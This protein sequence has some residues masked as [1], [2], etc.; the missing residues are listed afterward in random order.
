MIGRFLTDLIRYGVHGATKSESRKRGEDDLELSLQ[1]TS[2][3]DLDDI[4]VLVKA[5]RGWFLANRNDVYLGACL[6]RYGECGEIET[7]FLESLVSAGDTVIE[8][9]SNIGVH[10]VPLAHA[11]GVDGTLIALEPQPAIYRVLCANLALNGL[12]RVH[13]YM[14]GA[15]ATDHDMSVQDGADA[16]GLEHN[17]GGISLNSTGDGLQVKVVRIDELA[18]GLGRIDLIKIDVEGMELEVIKGATETIRKHRPLL[19]VENDRLDKSSTMIQAIM[20]LDYRLY[21][22]LPSLFNP[23]N[24]F[25]VAEDIYHVDSCNMLCVP[26]GRNHPSTEALREVVDADF[27]PWHR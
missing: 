23:D 5:R 27:H 6:L 25:R 4:N 13:P 22:H 26:K 18:K 7:V 11:L 12:Y 19:Y 3:V 21:W 24:L 15:G 16:F 9:G 2:T 20:A 17:S 8:V 1:R 10:T 14:L